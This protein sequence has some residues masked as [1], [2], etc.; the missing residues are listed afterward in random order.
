MRVSSMRLPCEPPW[1]SMPVAWLSVVP[2]MM[3]KKTRLQ[4]SRQKRA[5]RLAAMEKMTMMGEP[6]K[7]DRRQ[8]DQEDPDK[9]VTAG[10]GQMVGRLAAIKAVERTGVKEGVRETP[11]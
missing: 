9:R 1:R 10:V 2:G 7:V 6:Q 5:D 3:L 4:T 11:E 8:E